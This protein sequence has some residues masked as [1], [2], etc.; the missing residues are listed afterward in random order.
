M[1]PSSA[2]SSASVGRRA[3]SGS[4]AFKTAATTFACS[5]TGRAKISSS[6]TASSTR[7]GGLASCWRGYETSIRVVPGPARARS[8][9]PSLAAGL[10][11]RDGGGVARCQPRRL[12]LPTPPRRTR[13]GASTSRASARPR[14][15]LVRALHHHR[16]LQSFLYPLRDCPGRGHRVRRAH[17]RL[18][19]PRARSARRDP[20]GQR[21]T[22][23]R[24][25]T[26]WSHAPRR[27]T[28]AARHPA[29]ALQPGK[30]P[31]NGRHERFHRTLEQEAARPPKL[32][33]RF[34]QRAFDLFRREYNE[35]RPHEALGQKPP[36]QVYA[37]SS[38][39]YPGALISIVPSP[40][41]VLGGWRR[42]A[43]KL[44]APE[45]LERVLRERRAPRGSRG[46]TRGSRRRLR[47][48]RA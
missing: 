13:C 2:V 33:A 21:T 20:L 31:Q 27:L 1:S 37:P 7:P 40:P 45:F 28:P 25:R 43:G 9:P 3:T 19:L 17:P 38:R 30:P 16:R 29:R 46:G 39:R 48:R 18:G 11:L 42:L 14:R 5:R 47:S 12:R 41:A 6:T 24:A 4:L 23:C 34:Q 22:L 44:D 36:A 32:N 35:E 26:R 10:P 15:R 8:L